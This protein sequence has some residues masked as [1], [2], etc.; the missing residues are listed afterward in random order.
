MIRYH[1]T[2]RRTKEQID[3]AIESGHKASSILTD[4]I[5]AFY[6]ENYDKMTIREF[7]D[8]LEVKHP[9]GEIKWNLIK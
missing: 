4:L 7:R 2:P 8:M 5:R 6:S 3:E 1:P 9:K